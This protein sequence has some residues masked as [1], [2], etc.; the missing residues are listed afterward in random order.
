MSGLKRAWD[1]LLGLVY[2]RRAVCM[3]CGTRSGFPRDWLCETCREN[4]ASRWVGAG[5]VPEGGLFDGA[6]YGYYYGGPASGLV[7]H[8]KYQSVTRLSGL[9]AKSMADAY[10]FIEPTGAD[11][12]VPVPMHR[13]RLRQRGFNHAELLAKDTGANGPF[14]WKSA[15]GARRGSSFTSGRRASGTAAKAPSPRFQASNPALRR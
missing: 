5:R 2:P 10:A 9:M 11:G 1:A 13:K 12:L 14:T 15:Y 8:L 3:G 6:A 4:L 7:R